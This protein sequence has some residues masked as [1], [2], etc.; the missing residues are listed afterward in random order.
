MDNRYLRQVIAAMQTFLEHSDLHVDLAGAQFVREEDIIFTPPSS[1]SVPKSRLVEVDRCNQLAA[2]FEGGPSWIHGN[3]ILSGMC[4]PLISLA[5]GTPVGNPNPSINVSFQEIDL[6]VE[7][8][9][10]RA[11]SYASL[12]CSSAI[13]FRSRGTQTTSTDSK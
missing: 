7:D 2:L 8:H 1:W 11:P 3:L 12:D 13:A 6:V 4:P 10:L 9:D 5:T